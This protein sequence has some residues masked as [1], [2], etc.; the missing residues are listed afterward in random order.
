MLFPTK[1]VSGSFRSVSFRLRLRAPDGTEY[2]YF[3]MSGAMAEKFHQT[4]GFFI[5]G[6]SGP[7][8]ERE[9]LC[10]YTEL[11]DFIDAS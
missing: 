7:S 5:F 6:D 9:F 8:L 10:R 4:G 3:R 2:H 1:K 11:A